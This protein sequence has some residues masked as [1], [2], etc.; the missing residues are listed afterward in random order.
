MSAL[1]VDRPRRPVATGRL[2][3]LARSLLRAST[4]CAIATVDRSGRAHVNTAYFAYDRRLRLVWLSAPQA[5]HS[6]NIRARRTV[7]VAVYDSTQTW[8]KDDRGIQL[9]GIARELRG[10]GA[11]DAR[12]AYLAR[13]RDAA[14]TSDDYRCYE[15]RPTRVKLFDEG[16]LGGATFV[17][18][19][20]SAAGALR[21]LRTERYV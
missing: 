10:R 16:R 5:R 15:L 19:R 14:D 4:L 7:A 20:V 9:F 12:R 18:A 13:F 6:R 21:W 2:E 11:E 3:R 8:G 1:R 17:T